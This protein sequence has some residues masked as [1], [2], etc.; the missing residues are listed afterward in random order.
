MTEKTE[1]QKEQKYKKIA[2]VLI[3]LLIIVTCFIILFPQKSPL[4]QDLEQQ[5]TAFLLE[6]Y[7]PGSCYGMPRVI[8]KGETLPKPKIEISDH[9]ITMGRTCAPF[10]YIFD[11][12]I[13]DGHCCSIIIYK[14]VLTYLDGN[15]TDNLISNKTEDVPC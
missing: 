8:H 15:F 11:Y 3:S 12:E 10:E 5:A 4:P 7:K 6:K 9:C 1:Q 14:G 13:W 2:L